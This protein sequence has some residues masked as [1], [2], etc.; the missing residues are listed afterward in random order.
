MHDV[1]VVGPDGRVVDRLE[2][3]HMP[4]GILSVDEFLSDCAEYKIPANSR[5][6]SYTDGITEAHNQED[7]LFGEERLEKALIGVEDNLI[8]A[9][10]ADVERF[11]E[12]CDQKDDITI[13]QVSTGKAPAFSGADE[14]DNA[15]SGM[16][17][18][19]PIN[20]SALDIQ[21][22]PHPWRL[23]LLAQP[24][25]L[26]AERLVDLVSSYLPVS[27]NKS[28]QLEPLSA[29]CRQALSK[30]AITQRAGENAG[31]EVSVLDAVLLSAVAAEALTLPLT[32]YRETLLI[33]FQLLEVPTRALRL[34]FLLVDLSKKGKSVGPSNNWLF[35]DESP[36]LLACER[37]GIEP[38]TEYD[39][40]GVS[41]LLE[42]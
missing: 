6:I 18:L 15:H 11:Q 37:L 31:G 14:D 22:T 29:V 2:S 9:V 12:G 35:A 4:L 42:V 16:D 36:F 27:S 19:A 28:Y 21:F 3:D 1:L 38:K 25:Q 30:P 39:G 20:A 10:L 32:E 5:L 40:V 17:L 33:N 8:E 7:E 41:L 13:I 24:K 26:A 23:R 34:D